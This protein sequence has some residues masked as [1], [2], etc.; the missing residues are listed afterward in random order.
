MAVLYLIINAGVFVH[1]VPTTPPLLLRAA[2]TATKNI[3]I[4]RHTP[5]CCMI[6]SESY[7]VLLYETMI[8]LCKVESAKREASGVM[9]SWPAADCSHQRE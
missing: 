5:L 7:I 1:I 6:T 3:H 2:K 8:L 9:V 4:R